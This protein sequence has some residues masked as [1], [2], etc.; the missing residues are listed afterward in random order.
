MEYITKK[1]PKDRIPKLRRLQARYMLKYQK[2]ISEAELIGRAIDQ[3]EEVD[4]EE[5]KGKKYRLEELFGIDKSK[6]KGNARYD[7]DEVVYGSLR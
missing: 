6:T 2:R 5:N 4:L 3:L 7:V 1:V